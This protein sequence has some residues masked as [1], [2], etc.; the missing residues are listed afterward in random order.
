MIITMIRALP[1]CSSVVASMYAT[2]LYVT[3]AIT[4]VATNATGLT[5]CTPI[6][7]SPTV[8]ISPWAAAM[9][10]SSS[11]RPRYAWVAVRSSTPS[12]SASSFIS[13]TSMNTPAHIARFVN[14]GAMPEPYELTGYTTCSSSTV[15]ESM[16][17]AIL[18]SSSVPSPPN[19]ASSVPAE[20]N[21]PKSVRSVPSLVCT[22]ARAASVS[23]RAVVVCR[24]AWSS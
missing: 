20:D 16:K 5:V 1:T 19:R 18:R 3:E 2:A 13:A 7:R 14:S 8:T 15:G 21:A 17:S 4:P 9:T 11:Q 24:S 23:D 10:A 6:T 22:R 12:S